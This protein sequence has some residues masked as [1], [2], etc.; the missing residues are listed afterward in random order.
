MSETIQYK[1]L[2]DVPGIYFDCPYIGGM[3]SVASCASM[4]LD[5]MSPKGLKEGRRMHCRACPVGA[6]HAG[7]PTTIASAS[8]FLG[9]SY[10]SRCHGDAR[11]LIRGSICVSCYNREREV[12]IGK[13]AKGGKPIHGKPVN[14]TILACVFDNGE[15]TQV[16]RM[17]RVVSRLEAVLSVLRK[18]SRSISF[19]WVGSGL[20][21]EGK[22][23]SV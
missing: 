15:K 8:R 14:T 20:A 11:R 4:Y 1:T 22:L 13:N 16:R 6:S 10:C 3:L 21:R 17:D 9:V 12:L 18:E 23:E 19:G 7:V 2:E 5:A